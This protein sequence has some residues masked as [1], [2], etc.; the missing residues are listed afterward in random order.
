[1]ARLDSLVRIPFF[2]SLAL[3]LGGCA[4]VAKERSPT[5]Q[6]SL[7]PPPSVY[8]VLGDTA[9][10]MD[11]TFASK[12]P[13]KYPETEAAAGHRGIVLVR[14][15]VNES[16]VVTDTKIA[17]SSGWPILDANAAEAVSG[18]RF[19]P[20]YRQ[21]RPGACWIQCPVEFGR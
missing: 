12:H 3:S 15:L 6:V 7:V 4:Q 1:M 21:G 8:Q 9:V 2:F 11:L 18:W 17:R 13:P 20:C 19:Q 5:A 14:A 10:A 16:G